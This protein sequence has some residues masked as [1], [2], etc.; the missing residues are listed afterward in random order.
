MFDL[1]PDTD[2]DHHVGMTLHAFMSA[3]D[4]VRRLSDDEVRENE[5]DLALTIAVLATRLGKIAK[6]DTS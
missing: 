5:A 3:A 1:Q 4:D 6:P 2:R